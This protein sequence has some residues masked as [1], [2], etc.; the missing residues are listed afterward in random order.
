MKHPFG[1]YCYDLD[2]LLNDCKKLSTFMTRA[3]KQAESNPNYFDPD[4]YF[5]DAFEALVESMIVQ[6]GSSPYIQIK[7]YTPVLENDLGVDGYGY[8]ADGEIHTVQAKARGNSNQSLTANRDHISNFVAHS[9]AKFGGDS[10][11]K[12]MTIFTTAKDLHSVTQEMYNNEVKVLGN[13]EL[14]KLVD[15]NQMFWTNFRDQL[16]TRNGEYTG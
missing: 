4:K 6:M 5:G 8:G 10:K 15:N 9:H 11:V 1:L 7:D 2:Y 13:N 12:H 14:R 16:Q 3:R